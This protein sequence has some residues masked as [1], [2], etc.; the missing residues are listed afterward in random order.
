MRTTALLLLASLAVGCNGGQ[1]PTRGGGSSD[2]G[3]IGG[4]GGGGSGGVGGSGGLDGGG[5]NAD[6]TACAYTVY[7]H[8]NTVLYKIDLAANTLDIVGPFN[9]SNDSMTDL[10]VAPDDTIYTVSK[11][12]LYTASPT[13]GHVTLVGSIQTCGTDNVAL[14]TTPDGKLWVGDGAGSFCEIDIAVTPPTVKSIGTLGSSLAL[15][16]D[17]VGVGDGTLYGTALDKGNATVTGKNNILVTIDPATGKVAKQIGPTGFP[18]LYGVAYALG[19]VFGFTHDSSG[20]VITI[21]PQTGV[22][23]LY[24]TFMDPMTNKAISFAGAGVN[25]KVSPIP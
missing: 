19:K 6:P 7:A 25:S 5:C 1:L 14:S 16:G 4:A 10:A 17:L 22:G 3:G 9:A 24:K 15:S 11:M 12:N 8:S 23:T 20:R 18:Q 2:L 13:D 21:D